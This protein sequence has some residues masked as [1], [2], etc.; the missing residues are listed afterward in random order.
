[1]S[2][3]PGTL[4]IV[5]T[6]LGNP[7]DLSLRAREL[8]GSVDGVLAEDTRRSGQL[9]SRCGITPPPFTRLHDHNEEESLARITARL[10]AGEQLALVSD[11][12]T[13]LLSDP[14]FRLV[15]ACR[16]LGLRVAPLPGPFAAAAALSA[17]GLP[18]QPFVFL[19]FAPRKAG[20]RLAFFQPFAQIAATLVFYERKDRIQATLKA[21]ASVLGPREGCIARELTKVHEEFLPFRLEA[22][23][24]LP[25]DLLGEMTVIIGPP[26]AVVRTSL[27]DMDA[28]LAAEVKRGGGA[29]AVARRA[30]ERS[31]GWTAREIYARVQGK[32]GEGL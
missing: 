14:G 28:L 16:Q 9:F 24:S 5:A 12:G 20:E 17:C 10:L 3:K 27:A 18:P 23:D 32:D 30:K 11:A 13:P 15:R 6:P 25:L 8:L 19:G 7:G 22:P 26:E 2:S 31:S 29:R 4:W 1:M 21:A